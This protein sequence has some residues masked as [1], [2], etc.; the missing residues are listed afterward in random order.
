MAVQPRVVA[1]LGL[2]ALVPILAY[3]AT[4]PDWFSGLV[5]GVNIVVIVASLA[6]ALRP[7]G[8]SV[9]WG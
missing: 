5:T 1:A 7:T 2:L 9:A 4:Q 8:R 6:V 3:A